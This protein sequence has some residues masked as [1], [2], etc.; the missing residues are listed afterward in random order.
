MNITIGLIFIERIKYS[1][2]GNFPKTKKK[3]E[4]KFGLF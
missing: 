3:T 4:I 2:G 1:V